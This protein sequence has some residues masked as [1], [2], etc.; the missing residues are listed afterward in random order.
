MALHGKHTMPSMTNSVQMSFAKG[1]ESDVERPDA[2]LF[3][4]SQ[5]LNPK[6]NIRSRP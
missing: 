6:P 5:T 4:G 1:E 2:K 3:I